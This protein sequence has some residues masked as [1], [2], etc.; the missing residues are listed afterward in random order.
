MVQELEKHTSQTTMSRFEQKLVIP[1]QFAG[2]VVAWLQHTCVADPVYPLN[3]I[4]SLYLDTPELDSYYECL[5]GDPYKNKVRIRWYDQPAA[6]Q[7]IPAYIEL[8]SKRGA[9]TAKQRKQVKIPSEFLNEG[10][11]AGTIIQSELEK[12]LP[13][14]G[15][16]PHKY[17]RPLIIISY[18][19]YRFRE[20]LSGVSLTYDLEIASWMVEK[21]IAIL[22]PRLELQTT[23]LEIKGGT[24]ALPSALLGL[25]NINLRWSAFSKYARCLESHLEQPGSIGWLKSCPAE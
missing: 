8:K 3:T 10:K 5:N 12:T 20:P 17:L 2:F 13:E 18:R 11:I 14:L 9:N 1:P 23:V 24:M 6:D 25:R 7:D 16:M 15:Y 4:N 21:S 22:A 19:R